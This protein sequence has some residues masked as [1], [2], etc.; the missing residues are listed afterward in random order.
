[1][2]V[3]GFVVCVC[4]GFLRGEIQHYPTL[5]GALNDICLIP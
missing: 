5:P 4:V 3:A 1:M 2:T